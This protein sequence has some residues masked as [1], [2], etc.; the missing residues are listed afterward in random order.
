MEDRLSLNNLRFLG[1]LEGSGG[2][3]FPPEHCLMKWM[4]KMLGAD[5]FS[6]LFTKEFAGSLS[7][8]PQSGGSSAVN[9]DEKDRDVVLQK[10]Q[11]LPGLHNMQHNNKEQ[12]FK[13]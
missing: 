4:K 9:V 8:P 1:F 12:Q 10:A 2:E 13:G 6:P 11:D 3:E 5:T 7:G